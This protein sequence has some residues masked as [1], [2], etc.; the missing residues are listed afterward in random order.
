MTSLTNAV[1]H[2]NQQPFERPFSIALHG[3]RGAAALSVFVNH[4]FDFLSYDSFLLAPLHWIDGGLSAVAL[5]FVLSGTVLGISLRRFRPDAALYAGYAVK[6]AF[7][8]LP[9]IIVSCSIGFLYTHSAGSPAAGDIFAPEFYNFYQSPLTIGQLLFSWTGLYASPNPPMW[10]IYVEI[11][12]SVLLPFFVLCSRKPLGSA[13]LCACLLALSFVTSGANGHFARNHWPVYMVNF[14]VGL[15]L[16]HLG[17]FV[18]SAVNRLPGGPFVLVTIALYVLLM[19]GRTLFGLGRG[20]AHGDAACNLFDLTVASILIV[21]LMEHRTS[22]TPAPLWRF[23]GDI[24]YPLYALH[25]PILCLL[26]V[27][28]VRLFGTVWIAAHIE[29]WT[30]SMFVGSALLLVVL[31][32]NG[33]W[34][35]ERPAIAVGKRLADG[36]SRR[37]KNS[38]RLADSVLPAD[39]AGDGAAAAIGTEIK[40]V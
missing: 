37:S 14:S 19:N 20:D 39:G 26:L 23:L 28:S 27:G 33:Y 31:A 21:L 38:P 16:C 6:R 11:V 8:L 4:F 3:V 5:F 22:W 40:L 24:S 1:Q 12:A 13:V 34:W 30:I 29:L 25:W 17:R 9:M 15:L 18:S 2:R 36:L 7:R 10:S 32:W 35:L